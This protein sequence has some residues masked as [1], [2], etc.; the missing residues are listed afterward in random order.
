VY[1]EFVLTGDPFE[2]RSREIAEDT[3]QR[4]VQNFGPDHPATHY[5]QAILALTLARSGDPEQARELADAVWQN[6]RERFGRDHLTA[7]LAAAALT[8]ALSALGKT[9]EALELGAATV[10][11]AL[12]ELG[13]DH[14]LNPLFQQGLSSIGAETGSRSG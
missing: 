10:R 7:L 11:P 14:P 4:S 12:V 2:A 9:G 1:L 13:D 3:W 6:S 5:V 8:V